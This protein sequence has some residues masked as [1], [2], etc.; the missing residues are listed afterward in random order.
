MNAQLRTIGTSIV[1]DDTVIPDNKNLFTCLNCT[2]PKCRGTCEKI[3]H[4]LGRSRKNKE[5]GSHK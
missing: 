5:R 2:K 1:L 4:E 3:S